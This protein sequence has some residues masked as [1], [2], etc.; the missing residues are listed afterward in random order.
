MACNLSQ[1][2][3]DYICHN[4]G[5]T[6]FCCVSNGLSWYY[7]TGGQDYPENGGTQI[8]LGRFAMGLIDSLT[9]TNPPRG[10]FTKAQLDAANG[11]AVNIYDAQEINFHND[12]G[13]TG[14]ECTPAGQWCYIVSEGVAD[15]YNVV[16]NPTAPDAGQQL[17]LGWSVKNNGT[18]PDDLWFKLT[19][20]E[21]VKWEY[22][23]YFEP[24]E[25]E[26]WGWE[27]PDGFQ[28]DATIKVEAGH[29]VGIPYSGGTKHLDDAETIIVPIGS[30]CSYPN[31]AHEDII[32][33][34]P[35]YGQDPTHQY[36]CNDGQW[37]DD[38]W[39]SGCD[40]SEPCISPDGIHGVTQ[41]GD[42][43]HG[44]NSDHHY[45]C[46]DGQWVDDGW[47][48]ECDVSE[49]CTNPDGSHNSTRCVGLDRYICHDGVWELDMEN[50]PECAA[51]PPPEIPWTLIIAAGA[52]AGLL[53]A[54]VLLGRKKK[55]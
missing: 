25:S 43:A 30:S 34:D 11:S 1:A 36:T 51:A 10:T 49:P 44:Q 46:N 47:T 32:C 15:V 26:N 52:G 19:I 50:A 37:V 40:V 12:P 31:G 29:W 21:E 20:N 16:S 53:A 35:V 7:T 27:I 2:G 17:W 8:I 38:G 28:E 45:T 24:G 23:F 9:M 4:F 42:P 39:T 55:K 14:G 48:S 3:I 41:C 5:D 33:G 54:G 22:D 6:N 13:D 18:E